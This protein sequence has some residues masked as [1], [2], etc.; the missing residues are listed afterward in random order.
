MSEQGDILLALGALK[1]QGEESV[2]QRGAL[3]KKVADV[4]DVGLRTE[5]VVTAL[6]VRVADLEETHDTEIAPVLEDYQ[7]LKMKGAGVLVACGLLA[8]GVGFGEPKVWAA[9]RD[10]LGP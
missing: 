7:R 5:G 3:F 9:L 1:A 10:L 2:R 4:H 6:A 8:G